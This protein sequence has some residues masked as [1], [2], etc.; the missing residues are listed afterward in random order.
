MKSK[1]IALLCLSTLTAQLSTCFA[2]GTA[3]SYSGRLLVGTAPATGSYDMSFTAYDDSAAG[4]LVGGPV[5]RPA[6][7]V[8]DG[9]LTS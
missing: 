6:V 9:R 2:Q 8:S 3:F 4:N 5:I 1:L 7:T